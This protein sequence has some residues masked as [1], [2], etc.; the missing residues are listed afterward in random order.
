VH[1]V[2][3]SAFLALAA[4]TL[5]FLWEKWTR[6]IWT[7]G[8]GLLMPII[9]AFVA[10][11]ALKRRGVR[12]E[13]PSPWGFA[14]LM[15]ALAL[16]AIDSAIHTQLL[17]AFA[18]LLAL[19][20]LSLLLLGVQRTRALAFPFFLSLFILPIPGA[21]LERLHLLLREL[22]AEGT[23]RV[24][25]L[26]GFSAYVEGTYIYLPN[27]TLSVIEECSGFSALYAGI[28]ISLV[29]AYMSRSKLRRA[30]LVL[31]A[32]PL[33]LFCNVLRVTTLAILAEVYGYHLLDTSLHVLSGYFSFV[34]TLGILFLL[35]E[36]HP[37]KKAVA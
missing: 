14:F 25:H 35:A 4:P 7:N 10:A 9:L 22:T 5:V 31:A 34:L 27:G 36:R 12:Y 15:P 32:V 20:G 26:L 37:R 13:E 2:W 28:T 23:E 30:V 6:N 33:A 21:F 18:L 16:V 8:H 19:P 17:S 3:I 29:L 11:D 24:M 1:L